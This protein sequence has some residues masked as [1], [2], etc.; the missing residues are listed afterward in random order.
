MESA[1]GD[2]SRTMQSGRWV[3]IR[4]SIALI[5]ATTIAFGIAESTQAAAQAGSVT[6][7]IVHVSPGTGAINATLDGQRLTEA[8]EYGSTSNRLATPGAMAQL[9]V[10]IAGEPSRVLLDSTVQL[11]LDGPATIL[12]TG[13]LSGS[14]SPAALVL[15]DDLGYTSQ[16]RTRVRFVNAAAGS[17]AVTV[18]NG[19]S[20]TLFEGIDYG[21]MGDAVLDPGTLALR[22]LPSGASGM[23][24]AEA[25]LAAEPGRS[26]TAILAG[27]IGGS[28]AL[29]LV[30]LDHSRATQ[31]RPPTGGPAAAGS[32]LVDETFA[33]SATGLLPATAPANATLI[34]GYVDGEYS[35]RNLEVATQ[36]L[37]IPVDATNASIAVDARLIGETTRRTVSVGCRFASD[38]TGNRGYRL[39]VEPGVG[40]FRL[41]REDG[42]RDIF[43]RRDSIS[44]AIRRDNESN[45]IEITC[46]GNTITATI[47]GAVVASVI[48]NTYTS[49]S[50]VIG[51]GA[52]ASGLT[53]EARFDNLLITAR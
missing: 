23:P 44:Q 29:T 12:F 6:V 35:L 13:L 14:P 34:Y 38:S 15:A 22:V 2:H 37:P 8:L 21:G 3:I 43:L 16:D 42:T 5:L 26:Y 50:L 30:M 9:R 27:Q 31:S 19:D 52:R 47:N 25:R 1:H 33:D 45:R 17:G 11:P 18:M 51:V 49:G 46:A 48:D 24:L 40:L 32:V 4:L 7:R 28:T 41:V 20:T 39:R 36:S 53:S 10:S